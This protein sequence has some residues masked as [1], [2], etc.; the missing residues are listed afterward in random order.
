M[1]NIYTKNKLKL[2]AITLLSCFLFISG[3]NIA[4]AH[5]AK[6]SSNHDSHMMDCENGECTESSSQSCIEHCIQNAAPH[7]IALAPLPDSQVVKN[8]SKENIRIK[9]PDQYIFSNVSNET[10]RDALKH[11]LKIQKRE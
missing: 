7:Q 10:F 3:I 5:V 11:H 2:V 8:L 6:T 1:Q 4:H 9:I